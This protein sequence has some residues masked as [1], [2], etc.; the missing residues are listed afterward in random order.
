MTAAPIEVPEWVPAEAWADFAEMRKVMKKPLTAGAV[1]VAIKALRKMI[2][3][4]QDL[5]AVLEQSTL[6]CWLGL[7]PVK[8][9]QVNMAVRGRPPQ[10]T[11]VDQN[12]A[13][14]AEALRLLDAANYDSLR[15]INEQF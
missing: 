2:D 11:L 6:H 14:N 15:T 5:E 1:K 12:T 9:T 3:D 8:G 10:L 4:G 7:F 13:N